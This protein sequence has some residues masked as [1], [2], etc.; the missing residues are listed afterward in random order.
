MTRQRRDSGEL[1][2]E[3]REGLLGLA[4]GAGLQVLVALMEKDVAS[5]CGPHGRRDPQRVA[6]RHGT[7]RMCTDGLL[8][9]CCNLGCLV[10]S[11]GSRDNYV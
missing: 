11:C 10:F 8:Q 7:E 6:A 3:L 9:H 4:V 5:A 2:G 1:T